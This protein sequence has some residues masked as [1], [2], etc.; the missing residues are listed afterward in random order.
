MNLML[1]EEAVEH[2]DSD[3][4]FENCSLACFPNSEKEER[5]DWTDCFGHD[6][7]SLGLATWSLD[8]FLHHYAL[9]LERTAELVEFV[10]LADYD[11]LADFAVLVGS[12][13]L[14]GL[15]GLAGFEPVGVAD[16][17]DSDSV[18]VAETV[19]IG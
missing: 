19:D 2:F 8:S 5:H 9:S 6:Y 12:A 11:G 14:A 7:G 3:N 10:G 16:F 13:G 4:C 15:A 17:A 18:Q 1:V